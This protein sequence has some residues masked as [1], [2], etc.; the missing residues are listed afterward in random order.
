MFV[1]NIAVAVKEHKRCGEYQHDRRKV[2]PPAG[3]E[4][5]EMFN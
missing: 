5:K 1:N 4:S 3:D 2:W